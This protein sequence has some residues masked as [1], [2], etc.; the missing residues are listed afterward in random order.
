MASQA[1]EEQQVGRAVAEDLIGDIG[2]T[3]RDVLGLSATPLLTGGCRTHWSRVTYRRPDYPPESLLPRPG[4][5][6]RGSCRSGADNSAVLA[7]TSEPALQEGLAGLDW[8]VDR[9]DLA[10]RVSHRLFHTP[11]PPDHQLALPLV[12]GDRGRDLVER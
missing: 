6:R 1:V 8:G 10:E 5:G 12:L 7:Q 11:A 2:V 9:R 3:N 4:H